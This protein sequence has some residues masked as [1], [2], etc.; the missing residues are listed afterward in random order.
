MA[1]SVR[2]K[3]KAGNLLTR[4]YFDTATRTWRPGGTI[5]LGRE[6]ILRVVVRPGRE[7]ADDPFLAVEPTQ[8]AQTEE[9]L[10]ADPTPGLVI[11]ISRYS[12]R[13]PGKGE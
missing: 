6:S 3:C 12:S 10:D 7:P 1:V 9:R 11:R 4:R 5:P 8:D 13:R 2:L